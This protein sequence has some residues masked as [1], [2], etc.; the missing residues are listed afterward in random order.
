MATKANK[1]AAIVTPIARSVPTNAGKYGVAH[2]AIAASG[3]TWALTAAGHLPATSGHG[4]SGKPT[5][6]GIVCLALRL[7]TAKGLPATTANIV[8]FMRTNAQVLA[9]L[10]KVNSTPYLHGLPC[11][12]WLAKYIIG[13][14]SAKGGALIKAQ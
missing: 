5:V 14:A 1:A 8:L 10:G 12:N 11:H 3:T 13:T 9:L 6:H 4:K 7:V 2:K